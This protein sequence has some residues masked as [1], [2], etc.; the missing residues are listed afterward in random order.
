MFISWFSDI[1]PVFKQYLLI[2]QLYKKQ[3]QASCPVMRVKK[4][5]RWLSLKSSDES[6]S[7][8]KVVK[9]TNPHVGDIN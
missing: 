2:L 6:E 1:R 5:K 4:M 9:P 3:P 7:D 8:E